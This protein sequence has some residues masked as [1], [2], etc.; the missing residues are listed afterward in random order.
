MHDEFGGQDTEDTSDVEVG[1]RA[2]FTIR[3]RRRKEERQEDRNH[4]GLTSPDLHTLDGNREFVDEF[5]SY[6]NRSAAGK[7]KETL[8]KTT[9]CL[10]VG[11]TSWLGF[12]TSEY[13]Q[14]F[15]LKS[16]ID[17]GSDSPVLVNEPT[18]WVEEL[19]EDPGYGTRR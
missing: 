15:R 14:G 9:K 8:T 3:R 16:L 17:W 18:A 7:E 2:D 1:D 12:M 13:G 10:F 4:D 5:E 11:R 19:P 6:M